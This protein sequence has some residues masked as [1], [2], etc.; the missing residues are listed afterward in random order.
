MA[1]APSHKDVILALVG[2]TSALAGFVLVFLGV[3]VS[4]FQALLSANLGKDAKRGFRQASYVG[5]GTFSLCLLALVLGVS[6][7]LSPHD[8]LYDVALVAALA[9]L[10][11]LIGLSVYATFSVLLKG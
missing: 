4:E 10:V 7:L 3:L 2:V 8:P 9:A 1:D 11:A 6:W 5:F